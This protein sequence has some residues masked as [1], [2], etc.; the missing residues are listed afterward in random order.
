M[1]GLAFILKIYTSALQVFLMARPLVCW[2]TCLDGQHQPRLAPGR[3]NTV[4]NGQCVLPLNTHA[5]WNARTL[6]SRELHRVMTSRPHLSVLEQ[7]AA[8]LVKGFGS[9]E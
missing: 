5:F 1:Q 7:A 2:V 6:S 4:S 3:G 9:F 8:F